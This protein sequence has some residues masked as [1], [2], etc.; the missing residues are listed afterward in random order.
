[1][2]NT[3][4][5]WREVDNLFNGVELEWYFYETLTVSIL[6]ITVTKIKKF[7]RQLLFLIL[8]FYYL[9]K[10]RS[11]NS[12]YIYGCMKL[13]YPHHH[14]NVH[15]SPPLSYFHSCSGSTHVHYLNTR[16]S[17]RFFQGP[18]HPTPS[19]LSIKFIF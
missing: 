11:Y 19:T 17:S 12:V 14:W 6:Q 1:M 7:K 5:W 8:D 10:F 9:L 18:F 2:P 13:P 16:I 15:E 4:T 3:V